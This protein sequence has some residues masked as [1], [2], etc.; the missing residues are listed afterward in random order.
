MTSTDKPLLADADL[1]AGISD[2]DRRHHILAR[3][4]A[5]ASIK[6]AALCGLPATAAPTWGRS[7]MT[8]ARRSQCHECRWILAIHRDTVA[9]EIATYIPDPA[10][11]AIITA[12]LNSPHIG[13]QVLTAIAASE[14]LA[15]H[16]RDLNPSRLS[17]L[18]SHAS[19]HQPTVTLCEECV[20][21][22]IV[23][24]HG[25]DAIC[26]EQSVI[27]H[28]CTPHAAESWAGEGE[29]A[30]LMEC[31]VAAPCS[32]LRTLASYYGVAG[33]VQPARRAT[34]RSQLLLENR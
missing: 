9:T 1:V 32:A 19:R 14:E 23:N 28:G 22:G 30:L 5:D 10:D 8:A 21:F 4:A 11:S 27:C 13:V 31:T 26:P 7:N 6:T 18:L 20:D 34:P 16:D 25:F 17:Q 29:G 12:T 15:H 2:Y 24:A 3:T 33:G